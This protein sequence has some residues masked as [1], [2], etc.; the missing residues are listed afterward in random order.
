[1]VG[2]VVVVATTAAALCSVHLRASATPSL[3][4]FCSGFV[5]EMTRLRDYYDILT[6]RSLVDILCERTEEE[7]S[8]Q[9][10]K[11]VQVWTDKQYSSNY[12]SLSKAPLEAN[13]LRVVVLKGNYAAGQLIILLIFLS[14]SYLRTI[15]QKQIK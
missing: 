9:Q 5:R 10:R 14:G 1:M 6:P 3:V 7:E 12:P 4:G 8:S 11:S 2:V 15:F 13:F